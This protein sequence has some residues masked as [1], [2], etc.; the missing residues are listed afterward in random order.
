[1]DGWA[2][3]FLSAEMAAGGMVT[4]ILDRRFSLDVTVAE[5]GAVVP[6]LRMLLLSLAGGHATQ[7]STDPGNGPILPGRGS[8][9]DWI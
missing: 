4:V 3:P 9:L 8:S 1:M 2:V 6:S 7:E 5:V